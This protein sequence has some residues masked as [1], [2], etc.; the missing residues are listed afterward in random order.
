MCAAVGVTDPECREAPAERRVRPGH[1]PKR[2]AERSVTVGVSVWGLVL[3][4]EDREEG[5]SLRRRP[6]CGQRDDCDCRE[7]CQA[8]CPSE[9]PHAMSFH[10]L[11]LCGWLRTPAA[12]A[13]RPLVI[14][15]TARLGKRF[16]L[17]EDH[18]SLTCR[19]PPAPRRPSLAGLGTRVRRPEP[20]WGAG[21]RAV[22]AARFEL[23]TFRPPAEPKL[24][25]RC[26]RERPPRP[27]RP[28]PWTI[29]THRT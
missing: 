19:G 4:V 20:A 15:H 10:R 27:H 18:L 16:N 24:R 11:P 9:D 29:W 23:A 14:Q 2:S 22:G 26:V 1:V 17:L 6:G 28:R 12:V 8:R 7:R 13:I 21:L 25:C 3:A 5:G